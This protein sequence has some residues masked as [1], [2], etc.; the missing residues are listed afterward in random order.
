MQKTVGTVSNKQ[1]TA[2]AIEMFSVA[3]CEC[4]CPRTH[5]GIEV[6]RH[7]PTIQTYFQVLRNAYTIDDHMARLTKIIKKQSKI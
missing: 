5:P 1:E 6:I 7:D 4:L 3:V 2:L